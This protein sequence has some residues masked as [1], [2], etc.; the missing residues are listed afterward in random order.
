MTKPGTGL[1]SSPGKTITHRFNPMVDSFRSTNSSGEF[2][3][4]KNDRNVDDDQA[5]ALYIAA[6]QRTKPG[7]PDIVMSKPLPPK[8][9]RTNKP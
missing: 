8:S 9:K 3:S 5:H 6:K 1:S 7:S 4:C 2:H